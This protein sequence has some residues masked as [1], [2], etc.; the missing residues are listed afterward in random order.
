MAQINLKKVLNKKDIQGVIKNIANAIGTSIC[1]ED[2]QGKKLLGTLADDSANK[3]PVELAGEVIGWVSGEE[4]AAAVADMIG[5]IMKQ[6]LEKKGIANELLDKH[7][8]IERLHDI[9]TQITACVE[10]KDLAELVIEEAGKL[11]ESTGGLLMLLN[12]NTNQLEPLAQFGSACYFEESLMLGKGIIGRIIEKGRGEVV[13]DV[14]DDP[15]FDDSYQTVSSLIC[16]PLK[17]N[18]Q[19]IGGLALLSETSVNYSAAELQLLSMLGL[20]AAVAIE[21]AQLYEQRLRESRRESL[22]FQLT[23]QIHNSLNLDT[24]LETAVNEI[25]SFLQIERCLFV[26]QRPPLLC[27]EANCPI[28]LKSWPENQSSWEVVHEA[29]V[30]EL[31]SLIGYYCATEI[32]AFTKKLLDKGIIWVDEVKTCVDPGIQQSLMAQDLTSVMAFPVK[33]RSETT[34]ILICGNSREPKSWSGHEVLLLQLVANQLAIALD[35]G[36]LYEQTRMAAL[37]AQAQAQQMQQTLY[38]LKETQSQ[39]IQSEKMSS[40]GQLV[41]GVA[42]EINNPV[43]FIKGNLTYVLEYTEGLLKL[44]EAYQQHYPNPVA[45]IQNLIEEIDLDFL[46]GDLNKLL[47]SMHLGVDRIRQIVLSLRNFSRLD[48]ADMKPV[49]IHEGIDSTLLILQ[50]R[51]KPNGRYPGI[52]LIKEYGSLPL[53]ECYA[54]QLNQVFM[55]IIANAIDAIES[56]KEPGIITIR[57]QLVE[58]KPIT[59]ETPQQAADYLESAASAD[60]QP[61]S[62]AVILIRDNGCGISET[63]LSRLFDPFFTTKPVGK[64]TGLGLSISYQIVEKHGGLLKCLSKPGQGAAFWIQIPVKPIKTMKPVNRAI[65]AL[66]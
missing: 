52:K 56:Q 16:V 23:N 29:R 2:I 28:K 18:E 24:I 54:S 37:A 45:E 50:N 60:S 41:A 30:P 21:K 12:T 59:L 27:I 1:V 49:D 44:V 38:E 46:T 20:Q 48:E 61:F 39:L 62:H 40:L 43:N 53:V 35:Q 26:W 3:Y 65:A 31:P 13:N 42:H 19:V 57:T 66:H 64:G 17:T 63:V 33:T 34:G 10:L 4:K 6:E 14:L 5:Y 11:I 22:I 58:G 51:M 15:R 36:E 9:Y 32:G 25:R 55:N 47:S 8:E 7:K